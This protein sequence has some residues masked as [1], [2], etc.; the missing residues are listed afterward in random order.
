MTPPSTPTSS[1]A[2]RLKVPSTIKSYLPI[3]QWAP[4]YQRKE[5]ANDLLAGLIVAIMLVPQGMAYALLA[6]LPPQ[7]GL[8]ASILPLILYGI[9]GSSRVLAVGPV[10]IVSLL[11]AE[12]VAPL[13]GG[14]IEL[15]LQLAVTLALMVALIQIIMGLVRLGFIVNFMSHPVLAGFTSAAAFIIGFS[16]LRHLLGIPMPRLPFFELVW[17]AIQHVG[18]TN[19][20]TLGMGASAIFIL[21]VFKRWLGHFLQQRGV[22]ESVAMPLAKSA[23]L[24]IILVGTL[25]VW[26][27]Q[28]QAVAGVQVVG[29]VPAGLPSLTGPAMEMEVWQSL[30]PIG[31]TISFVG[32]MESIA[33]AKSLAN[34]R[35]QKVDTNQELIALGIANL[36]ATFTGG[37][38][39]TGGFS[40]SVVNFEAGARTGLA[41]MITA[42]FITLTVTFITP[43]FYFIPQAIL[44][45]IVMVAVVGLIDIKTLV[46]VW[47]YNKA[48]AASYIIT[49]SSVLAFGVEMGI[50]AGV[51]AAMILFIWRTS[52]PHVAIVGQLDNCEIYRNVERHTVKTWPTIVAVRI[53]QSLYFAN[54]KFL[55]D[56]VLRIVAEQPE[57]EHF[58]LIGTAI[59]FIDASALE[60]LEALDTQLDDAG[61]RLHLAAIKGPVMDKL[62]EIGFIDQIGVDR[63]H[64]STHHAIMAIRSRVDTSSQSAKLE[65][66]TAVTP[67][68][69]YLQ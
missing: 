31:L 14:D 63:V 49:F 60:T 41:S 12:G 38:P 15:Y 50:L 21:F 17:Y 59:N 6:G 20:V 54:S 22:R 69:S 65:A 11:V 68:P 55:E 35:R 45:A 34:K 28:L 47:Q 10:A 46:H 3:L 57:V 9:F 52:R 24:L 66:E 7:A 39:V 40:R 26:G 16:Q 58:V 8:Y 1:F 18:E 27:F 4:A 25:I 13:A 42:V 62:I 33:V 37:Y 30:L 51:S 29:E 36:G 32:Y 43:L 61:V 44:A 19:L 5:L 48:D 56:S 53:D 23:P 64:I 67:R 2:S